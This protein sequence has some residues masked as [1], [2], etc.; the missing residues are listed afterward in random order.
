MASDRFALVGGKKIARSLGVR[1][2]KHTSGPT[3]SVHACESAFLNLRWS[4]FFSLR[5]SQAC[6]LQRA[7]ST[8]NTE[9]FLFARGCELIAESR[10]LVTTRR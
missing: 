7:T 2:P 10:A 5:L 9:A 3:T 8:T 4:L 1:T 6:L